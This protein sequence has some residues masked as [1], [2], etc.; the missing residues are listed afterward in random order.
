[1]GRIF[2][3]IAYLLL[4]IIQGFAEILPISS[5][6]HLLMLKK[7][8]GFDLNNLMLELVLHFASL[9]ALFIFYRKLIFK[10][11]KGVYLYLFKKDR[12]NLKYYRMFIFI[13]LAIIPSAVAGYFLDDYFEYLVS[14][15]LLIGI[16]F[17][18]NG[19]NL[20]SLKNVEGDKKVEGTTFKDILIVGFHR[21]IGLIP[22]ISRSGSALSGC[23]RTESIRRNLVK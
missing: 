6:G 15:T 22:G 14:S 5:S 4:A 12:E 17:I 23:Y 19:I 1:M 21:V 3:L 18:I 9:V 16:F 13:V 10:I 8:L 20:Y 7:T 2:I 11:I